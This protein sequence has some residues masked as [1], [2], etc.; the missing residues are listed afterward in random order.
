MDGDAGMSSIPLDDDPLAARVAP[1]DAEEVD[2]PWL[3]NKRI[4][5][6]DAKLRL[7]LG[8]D[9]LG[10][11][12]S[13]DGEGETDRPDDGPEEDGALS[14]DEVETVEENDGVENADRVA[15]WELVLGIG[16]A[17]VPALRDDDAVARRVEERLARGADGAPRPSALGAFAPS[18]PARRCVAAIVA[19]WRAT[20]KGGDDDAYV[21][22]AAPFVAALALAA[23]APK[24]SV[25][26]AAL[27]GAGVSDG[28]G[29]LEDSAL[30]IFA[31]VSDANPFRRRGA[32]DG[33]VGRA[34][35]ELLPRVDPALAARVGV[36]R[37]DVCGGGRLW[38]EA[39][40]A[41]VDERDALGV[42]DVLLPALHPSDEPDAGAGFFQEFARACVAALVVRQRDALL[43]DARA[44][45][46]VAPARDL[47]FAL[48]RDAAAFRDPG[49]AAEASDDVEVVIFGDGPLGILLTRRARGLVVN[50]FSAAKPAGRSAPNAG[51]AMEAVNGR[52]LPT[53]ATLHDAVA[54][55]RG[56]GRP[57]AVAF[58]RA[59]LREHELDQQADALKLQQSRAQHG[60]GGAAAAAS[61]A[62]GG[63]APQASPVKGLSFYAAAVA[64]AVE[65]FP[66]A[67]ESLGV[68]AAFGTG[69]PAARAS[70]DR[71]GAPQPLPEPPV[72]P[73]GYRLCA[74]AGE[75][76]FAHTACVLLDAA[77]PSPDRCGAL[78]HASFSGELYATSYR[79][80]FHPIGVGIRPPFASSGSHDWEMPMR[81]LARC[82]LS[83]ANPST[84]PPPAAAQQ[85]FLVFT[86]KDGQRRR[87]SVPDR[88]ADAALNVA[89]AVHA[90]AFSRAPDAFA[91]AHF[92]GLMDD[93]LAASAAAPP[94][95]PKDL[96]D[97]PRADGEDSS[98]ASSPPGSPSGS[99]SGSLPP[100]FPLRP[101]ERAAE[102]FSRRARALPV[103]ARYSLAGEYEAMV[104]RPWAVAA[105]PRRGLRLVTQCEALALCETYPPQLVV[106]S[107]LSDLE[108]KRV[109]AYR[110]KG[111]L[112]VVV[113]MS[114]DPQSGATISR[115]SQPKPGVQNKRSCDDERYVDEL[116]RLC[117]AQKLVI[118][119]ARSKVAAQGN[120]MMG[121]G[122]ELTKYYEGCDLV[123]GNVANIHAAR[124][125]LAA[126]HALCRGEPDARDSEPGACWLGK[127][128]ASTWLKQVHAIL[129]LAVRAVECVHHDKA[130]V[131]VHCSDGWD[132]T[133]Q[134]TVLALLML[135]PRFRTIDGFLALVQRE[136][137]DFGHKF[138][139]RCGH[140]DDSP[141]EQR[142]P[143][144][145]LFVDTVFQLLRQFPRHFEFDARLLLAMQDAVHSCRYGT[146]LEDSFAA[147]AAKRLPESTAPFWWYVADHAEAF[148]NPA[149]APA[150]HYDSPL[151]PSLSPR[152]VCFFEDYFFRFDAAAMPPRPLQTYY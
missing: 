102:A 59:T 137:V 109:C 30:A 17:V 72:A 12:D 10:V 75:V 43:A 2:A 139:E 13:D 93:S 136:W 107:A 97:G 6:C 145:L 135:E 68:V 5:D 88:L 21:D 85:R 69:R 3:F 121:L 86:A 113:W 123:Y 71:E 40:F 77:I 142:A 89:R 114:P 73:D 119:D 44:M 124:D 100:P 148:R 144:F 149:Y 99:P 98:G 22:G 4:D 83:Q 133:P 76:V 112:P 147:R 108:L 131:L 101:A 39:L 78:N 58:R 120:R 96:D 126:V 74:F 24:A 11:R 117:A 87:F 20:K 52:R 33:A 152:N 36:A 128:D 127:L 66:L 18:P 91:R 132:R 90:L 110:S 34:L 150:E 115:A 105:Y 41:S 35:A 65:P 26:R 146:F 28:G 62:A 48:A 129:A 23:V 31:A 37:A 42:W 116:R 95:A 106:P 125:A 57:V 80:V 25:A 19:R 49:V 7:R 50:G 56:V 47:E 103:M 60:P 53:S 79:L 61:P 143:V 9:A 111:R 70:A 92:S 134:V 138:D 104:L 46:D 1:A 82:E 54:L 15:R 94:E 45:V 14:A 141:A 38:L 140:C 32:A 8:G 67:S 63:Y 64:A 151:V 130:A 55:L 84:A 118:L 29:A 81:S 122:T 27:L 51:D 16:A